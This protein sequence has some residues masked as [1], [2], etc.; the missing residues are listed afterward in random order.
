LAGEPPSPLQPPPGCVFHTRC[1]RADG[2]CQTIVPP[3]REIR[4]G[5]FAACVKL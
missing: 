2:D 5:H 4:A 1:P 3:L